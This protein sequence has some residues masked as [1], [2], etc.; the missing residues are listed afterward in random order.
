MFFNDKEVEILKRLISEFITPQMDYDNNGLAIVS[1]DWT[2]EEID[3]IEK[4][5]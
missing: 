4:L 3:L 2:Q 1:E 5:D